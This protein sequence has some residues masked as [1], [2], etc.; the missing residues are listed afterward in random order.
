M[1]K[2]LI[3]ATSAL[4]LCASATFVAANPATGTDAKPADVGEKGANGAAASTL[5]GGMGD[6]ASGGKNSRD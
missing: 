1:K 4:A 5:K 6:H 2:L 3:T